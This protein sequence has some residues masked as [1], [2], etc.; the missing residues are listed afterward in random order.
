MKENILLVVTSKTQYIDLEKEEI[1]NTPYNSSWIW[2]GITQSAN[3]I[4]ISQTSVK[5]PLN[6]QFWWPIQSESFPK[7]N[8]SIVKDLTIHT[9]SSLGIQLSGI[10]T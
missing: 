4:L 3:I 8:I 7:D 6:H 10:Q 5:I 9:N 1:I 2:K